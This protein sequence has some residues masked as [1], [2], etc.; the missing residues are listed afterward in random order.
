MRTVSNAISE[1][2]IKPF[3]DVKYIFTDLLGCLHIH[4][5][6]DWLRLEGISGQSHSSPLLMQG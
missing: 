3:V 6:T 2:M 4:R 1:K 5:M